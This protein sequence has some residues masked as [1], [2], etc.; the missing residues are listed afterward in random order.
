MFIHH[1]LN[2]LQK[3]SSNSI[4]RHQT[5]NRNPHVLPRLLTLTDNDW[6]MGVCGEL[7]SNV[8][9]VFVVVDCGEDC[10]ADYAAKGATGD[11]DGG[12]GAD[13]IGRDGEG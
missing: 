9:C 2:T 4:R 5:R 11:G 1:R 10:Y 12:G 8:R 7:G 6:S 13:E 3:A